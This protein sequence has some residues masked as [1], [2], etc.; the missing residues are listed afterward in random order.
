MSE[1]WTRD[2]VAVGIVLG[3]EESPAIDG[4]SGSLHSLRY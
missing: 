2:P 3:P 4:K 1:W